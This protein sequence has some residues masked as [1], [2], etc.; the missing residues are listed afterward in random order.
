MTLQELLP[1][2]KEL[3]HD[4]KIQA[5]KFLNAELEEDYIKTIFT[6]EEYPIYT[7][8]GMEDAALKVMEALKNYNEQ[9]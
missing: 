7:P 8:F 1:Q 9:T 3:S 4:E 6:A 5:V 2:L